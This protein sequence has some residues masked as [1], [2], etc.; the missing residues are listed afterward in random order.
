VAPF[1]KVNNDASKKLDLPLLLGPIMA[2]IFGW[3]GPKF[4]E[5]KKI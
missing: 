1:P 2:F 3:K 4:T 5:P